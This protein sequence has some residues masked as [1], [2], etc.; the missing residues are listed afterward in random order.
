[1]LGI[2]RT[3][4]EAAGGRESW[5]G[6]LSRIAD[7]FGAV[8][9]HF[10]VW[11]RS[12]SELLF[13]ARAGRF[14][15]DAVARYGS[16]FCHVDS[17]LEAIVWSQVG[18][19]TLTQN[20]RQDTFMRSEI[21]NDFLRPLGAKYVMGVKLTNSESAVSMLRIH[22]TARN[23]PYSKE[24][25]GKLCSA[26][27]TLSF[28]AQLFANQN[29][30]VQKTSVAIAALNQL[31]TGVIVVS[32]DGRVLQ[33]NTAAENILMRDDA[34]LLIRQGRLTAKSVNADA[35][36]R[37][38]IGRACD[39]ASIKPQIEPLSQCA[40]R[41]GAYHV[42]ASPL[43]IAACGS[44]DGV[45][46]TLEEVEACPSELARLNEYELTPA[47]ARIARQILKGKSLQEI[48][49]QS[50][51]SINTVKTHVKAIFA[52]MQVSSQSELVRVLLA[53]RT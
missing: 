33:M 15:A 19:I 7:S 10:T 9:A 41:F 14:P 30:A 31:R 16:Y 3:F 5:P 48:A 29:D 36:L 13:S 12:R 24:D 49:A 20:Y 43:A 6:A 18:E 23:G 37:R 45:L 44:A 32:F 4:S 38:M 51:I 22:R 53:P 17:C 25:I 40:E 46:I 47:Q 39:L 26:L 34:T 27:P 2:A 8:E 35:V 42:V 1:M 50:S 21:Y 28:A 11:N 52:K